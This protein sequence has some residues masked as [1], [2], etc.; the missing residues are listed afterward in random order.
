MGV[1]CTAEPDDESP[2]VV[3]LQRLVG[4]D[5]V[6]RGHLGHRNDAGADGNRLGGAHG[7]VEHR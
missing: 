7:Y 1:A 4:R 5:H 6:G 2:R 3:T